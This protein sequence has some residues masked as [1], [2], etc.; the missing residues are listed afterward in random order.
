[1]TPYKFLPQKRTALFNF[2]ESPKPTKLPR[3]LTDPIIGAR[4]HP[5]AFILIKDPELERVFSATKLPFGVQFEIARIANNKNKQEQLKSIKE[6]IR[7]ITDSGQRSRN[8]NVEGVTRLHRNLK[9]ES[10]FSHA[11]IAA[12]TPWLALDLEEAVLSQDQYG[13]VGHRSLKELGLDDMQGK[14]EASNDL[15]FGDTVDFLAKMDSLTKICL[16]RAVK[17]PSN[18]LKRRFGSTRI[19]RCKIPEKLLGKGPE[20][21]KF[22]EQPIALWSW[23]FRAF[24]AKDESVYLFRTNETVDGDGQ[25]QETAQGLSVLKL[26]DWINSLEWNGSQKM[27]KWATRV[28]LV[29]SPSVPG[30]LLERHAIHE[31]KDIISTEG[32]DLTDGCGIG[33]TSF[34]RAIQERYGLAGAPNAIQF[35]LYGAKGMLL[36]DAQTEDKG[37]PEIWL[38]QSQIKIRYSVKPDIDPSHLTVDILRLSRVRSPARLSTEVII[39]LHHNGVPADVFKDIAEEN[40]KAKIEPFFDFGVDEQDMT[41]ASKRLWKTA[42]EAEN[43]LNAVKARHDV[44]TVRFR[45]YSEQD[46]DADGLQEANGEA[47][48]TAW[49]PDPCSGCPSSIAETIMDLL[50]AGFHPR[51]CTF[52]RDKI[53]RLAKKKIE[54]MCTKHNWHM[55]ASATAYAVPDPYAVLGPNQIYFRS[56]SKEFVVGGSSLK[57]DIVT[58]EVLITRSPCK[59]PTDVRKVQSIDHPALANIHDV[60]VFPVKGSRRLIDFLAGGDYDGDRVTVIWNPALVAPFTNSPDKFSVEPPH[61]KQC[62]N[63]ETETVKQF[64]IRH[65]QL[66]HDSERIKSLQGYLLGGLQD[67]FLVGLYSMRHDKWTYTHG[68]HHELTIREAYM[69]CAVLDSLKSGRKL[70][71]EVRRRDI[72]YPSKDAVLPWKTVLERIS[73]QTNST[74]SFKQTPTNSLIRDHGHLGRFIM[75]ELSEVAREQFR[76]WTARAET[77][78][79]AKSQQPDKRQSTFILGADPDLYGPWEKVLAIAKRRADESNPD[80]SLQ[81]D[82]QLIRSHVESVMNRPHYLNKGSSF[83][84]KSIVSRQDEIRALSREFSLRPQLVDMS[85]ICDNATL[86]RLRASCAYALCRN[87]TGYQFPWVVAFH[88]LCLMKAD[89]SSSFKPVIGAFADSLNLTKAATQA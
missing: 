50:L 1:M 76:K 46:K 79:D 27:S 31:L 38:R 34:F 61:I 53:Y 72:H 60:V 47:Q 51:N 15:Y 22:F 67:R 63:E 71:P 3:T 28:S 86:T 14:K 55:A 45:G 42:E 30:P 78:F 39:N 62:F 82:L 69:F 18:K 33:N 11:E 9:L 49:W 4:D 8:R 80:Y 74:P 25:I 85:S 12:T 87:N 41:M 2:L 36:L 13:G 54:I 5:Q 89:S 88:E 32:S 73:P 35:R 43:V 68:L 10:R 65:Y 17:A 77:I 16:E 48:S 20:I 29:L 24:Y 7:D 66:S 21:V 83:T 56:S 26:V 59:L 75:D 37:T 19:M 64:S 52:L 70:L 81:N 40:L 84:D 6:H 23:V 57:T 58:G 44:T